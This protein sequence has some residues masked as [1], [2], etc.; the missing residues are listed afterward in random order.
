MKWLVTG[1]LFSSMIFQQLVFAEDKEDDNDTPAGAESVTAPARKT[2]YSITA[3]DADWFSVRKGECNVLTVTMTPIGG[4]NDV[5]SLELYNPQSAPPALIT[6]K[7]GLGSTRI[8]L[9]TALYSDVVFVRV[10]G[11]D[12]TGASFYELNFEITDVNAPI[13]KEIDKL[14]RLKRRMEERLESAEKKNA[15]A[16]QRRLKREITDVRVEIQRLSA[17]LCF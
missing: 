13:H 14:K 1:F 10:Y 11:E 2:A 15:S 9:A 16:R 4:A 6:A 3:A 5:F 12:V 7:S 8:D 17:K